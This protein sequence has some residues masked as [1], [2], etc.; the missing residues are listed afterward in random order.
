[1]E[2]FVHSVKEVKWNIYFCGQI[3]CFDYGQVAIA[4]G[5][6]VCGCGLCWIGAVVE[7]K[8]KDRDQNEDLKGIYMIVCVRI[9]RYRLFIKW[10]EN[11]FL[12]KRRETIMGGWSRDFRGAIVSHMWTGVVFYTEYIYNVCRWQGLAGTTRKVIPRRKK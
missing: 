6:A 12:W 10:V 11:D 1:M 2:I 4:I 9:I 8:D 3:F 5:S 7:H